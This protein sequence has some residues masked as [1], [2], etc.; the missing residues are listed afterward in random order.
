MEKI[1]FEYEQKSL[2]FTSSSFLFCS[3]VTSSLNDS[4]ESFTAEWFERNSSNCSSSDLFAASR[5]YKLNERVGT[6]ISAGKLVWLVVRETTRVETT[7]VGLFIQQLQRH[8][9]YLRHCCLILVHQ[10]A[11]ARAQRVQP[12][13]AMSVDLIKQRC[14]IFR[15]FAAINCY[16][17]NG[18]MTAL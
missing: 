2:K 5:L 9:R 7:A 13:S 1:S 3:R 14:I 17:S 4:F 18:E 10:N 16:H 15:H 8:R 11:L 12:M 6:T